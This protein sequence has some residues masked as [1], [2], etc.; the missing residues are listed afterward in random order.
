VAGRLDPEVFRQGLAWATELVQGTSALLTP[1]VGGYVVFDYLLDSVQAD[2][3]TPAVPSGVWERLLSDLQ[4][5]DALAV[6]VAAYQA[7]EHR[8]AERAWQTAA[9][10]GDHSAETN[11]GIVLKDLGRL[12]EAEAWY[13]RAADAGDH[14]AEYNLG[15]LLQELG[16][17][18]EAE[19]W[20]Q[21]AADGGNQNA[22]W[23]LEQWRGPRRGAM[24]DRD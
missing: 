11:L 17:L 19:A 24:G 13:Q 23:A 6:G 4:V 18:D 2:P 10:A 3:A 14:G 7:G 12:D 8:V 22:V 5:D 1:E 15:V 20:Y 9:D 16:R 21:R